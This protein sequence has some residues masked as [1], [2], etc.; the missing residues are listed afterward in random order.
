MLSVYPNDLIMSQPEI[1][2]VYLKQTLLQILRNIFRITEIDI[3]YG[4]MTN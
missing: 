3:K 4:A 2:V 1:L